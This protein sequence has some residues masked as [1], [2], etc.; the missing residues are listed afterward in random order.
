V[1]VIIEQLV[2]RQESIG[3]ALGASV[4]GGG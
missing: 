2:R 4:D 1:P 3:R